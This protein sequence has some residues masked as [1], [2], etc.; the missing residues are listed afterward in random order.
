[1]EDPISLAD[2]S[3]SDFEKRLNAVFEIQVDDGNKFA[4]TLVQV[5]KEVTRR[6]AGREGFALLFT[7]TPGLI[8]P[9]RIYRL[10][11][12]EMGILDI[13]LVPIGASPQ[14]TQYQAVFG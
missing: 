4:I 7:G 11:H 12:A 10:T 2:L 6:R 1:M 9:Q 13:F 5:T 3:A 14:A 8:L